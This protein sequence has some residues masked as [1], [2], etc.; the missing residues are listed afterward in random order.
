[1]EVEISRRVTIDL[2][3]NE[4]E[5]SW[6]QDFVKDARAEEAQLDTDMRTTIKNSLSIARAECDKDRRMRERGD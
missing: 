5:A 3:M 2:K 4:I 1:M 6:L